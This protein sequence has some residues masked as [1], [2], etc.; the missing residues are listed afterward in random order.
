MVLLDGVAQPQ[1]ELL[2][3]P[4]PPDLRREAGARV[5]APAGLRLLGPAGRVASGLRRPCDPSSYVLMR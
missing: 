2:I 5:I 1:E 3:G 4:A